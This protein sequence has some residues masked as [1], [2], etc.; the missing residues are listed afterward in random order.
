MIEKKTTSETSEKDAANAAAAAATMNSSPL[1][2]LA[3]SSR[4]A[5]TRAHASCAAFSAVTERGHEKIH[6]VCFRRD[7]IVFFFESKFLWA[8]VEE[9]SDGGGD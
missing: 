9:Q 4:S 2:L 6:D 5:S 1:R 3:R 8:T 7:F